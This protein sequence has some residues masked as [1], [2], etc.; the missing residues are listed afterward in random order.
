MKS[1]FWLKFLNDEQL[2]VLQLGGKIDILDIPV[3]K[4]ISTRKYYIL[5]FRLA[6]GYSDIKMYN[7]ILKVLRLDIIATGFQSDKRSLSDLYKNRVQERNEFFN[8]Q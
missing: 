6:R 5:G 2:G 7:H 3:K 8:L 1:K 4:R